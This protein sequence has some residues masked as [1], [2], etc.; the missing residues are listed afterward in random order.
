MCCLS[1]GCLV[2]CAFLCALSLSG[3]KKNEIKP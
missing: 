1:V 2:W 3:E